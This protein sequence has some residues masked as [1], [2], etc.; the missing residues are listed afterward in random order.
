MDLIFEQTLVG[1]LRVWVKWLEAIDSRDTPGLPLDNHAAS[2]DDGVIQPPRTT[3][4]INEPSTTAST[5]IVYNSKCLQEPQT[6]LLSDTTTSASTR[7]LSP[8]PRL[9]ELQAL[10]SSKA[11]WT[12][13]TPDQA[14]PAHGRQDFTD[15]TDGIGE[16]R[17]V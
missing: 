3:V 6:S 11:I 17:P 16:L 2:I 8:S 10:K 7:P 4:C 5:R 14:P 13:T 9:R 12:S 1:R 15:C